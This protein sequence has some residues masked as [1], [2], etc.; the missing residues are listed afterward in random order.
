MEATR[1]HFTVIFENVVKFFVRLLPAVFI[2]LV[3]SPDY[4]AKGWIVLGVIAAAFTFAVI[5]Q[6]LAW[7]V[8]WLTA[9]ADQLRIRSGLIWKVEKA[10]P[11]E[12]I[13]TIDLSRNLFQRVF[14]TCRIKIDT[15]AVT[16]G[17]K[18]GSEVNLVY[19]I[20]KAE[21]IRAAILALASGTA[22][23]SLHDDHV[24]ASAATATI[25]APDGT[26]YTRADHQPAIAPAAQSATPRIEIR[27]R[28]M[29]FFLYGLTESKI[30]MVLGVFFGIFAFAQDIFQDE[31]VAW[32]EKNF[33]SVWSQVSQV[34][35]LMAILLAAGLLL[36]FYLLANFVSILYS[37]VRFYNFRTSR[38]GENIHIEYGLLTVKSYTLPIKNIHAVIINQ[39]LLRR[40]IRQC[41][42]EVVSIGYGDE[43]NEVALLFPMVRTNQ[44]EELM[45]RILPE[46]QG[47]TELQPAPSAALRRYL[48]LPVLLLLAAVG[49]ASLFWLPALYSLLVLLPWLVISRW[50]SYRHAGIGYTPDRLEV[51]KGGFHTRRYRIRMDAVQSVM[52]SSHPFME[53]AGLRRYRIDYHAPTMRSVVLVEFMSERHLGE[54]RQLLDESEA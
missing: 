29:D 38:E 1:C 19:K 15:G 14:G 10:V 17:E 34:G 48:L 4:G 27:A 41:S 39:N 36:A 18:K 32:F 7:R 42:V 43:K 23:A 26:I 37:V 6:A 44:L 52:A 3:A 40:A 28:V 25:T 22:I 33:D 54:L 47:Q 49:G 12:K 46:Y 9:E 16:G 31:L 8:T 53:R 11:Y 5:Y 24:E 35:L 13:N 2:P 50:L 21:A 51:R 45:G 30:V 20:D